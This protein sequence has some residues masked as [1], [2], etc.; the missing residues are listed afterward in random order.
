MQGWSQFAEEKAGRKSHK[1]SKQRDRQTDR[2]DEEEREGE[3]V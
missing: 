2:L 3:K 1:P